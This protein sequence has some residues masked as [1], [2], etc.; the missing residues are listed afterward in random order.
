MSEDE[1][2][3]LKEYQKHYHDAKSLNI[4]INKIIF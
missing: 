1:K 2:K 4:V 3:R